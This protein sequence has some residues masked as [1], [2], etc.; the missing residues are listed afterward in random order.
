[1]SVADRLSAAGAAGVAQA[2]Q[3][4]PGVAP[5]FIRGRSSC[6]NGVEVES[7]VGARVECLLQGAAGGES[8]GGGGFVG[9]CGGVASRVEL[10]GDAAAGE[11]R[12]PGG[13]P[14]VFRTTELTLFHAASCRFRYSSW[15]SCGVRYPSAE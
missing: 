2:K 12:V 6:C 11:D 5:P 9:E 14:R 10:G 15:T 8:E 1:V 13:P 3:P 4:P 7:P